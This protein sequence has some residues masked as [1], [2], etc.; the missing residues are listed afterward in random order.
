MKVRTLLFITC[1]FFICLIPQ[2]GQPCT[3]FCLGK[4]DQLVFGRN[5][6]WMVED[7]LVIVNKRGVSK[8]AQ[9]GPKWDKKQPASWTSKYGSITFNQM[10]RGDP[11]GGMNETGLVIEFMGLKITRYPEPDSRP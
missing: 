1:I 6:D 9:L 7:C 3:T 8:T 4:G 11:T 2:I 10:G 5:F